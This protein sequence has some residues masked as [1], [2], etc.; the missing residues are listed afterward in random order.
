MSARV[1]LVCDLCPDSFTRASGNANAT[2]LRRARR[3]DGWA[4]G[5]DLPASV[6]ARIYANTP[7]VVHPRSVGA[8]LLLDICPRCVARSIGKRPAARVAR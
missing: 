2:E 4:R 5:K 1:T 7:K 8:F 3:Q 6:R